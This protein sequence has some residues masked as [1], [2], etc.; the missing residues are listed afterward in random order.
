MTVV[1][2]AMEWIPAYRIGFYEQLRQRLDQLDVRLRVL[3][4]QPPASR[5]ARRDSATL[6]WFEE[7]TNRFVTV[8]RRELTLQTVPRDLVDVDVV[9]V[10]HEVGLLLNYPLAAHR[11]LSSS[12]RLGFWGHG[13]N[14]VPGLRSSRIESVRDSL[15][16]RGD[17]IFAYTERSK[18][19]YL[20]AG[21]PAGRITVV[22][23]S[24]SIPQRG[25][26]VSAEISALVAGL[27]ARSAHV[28]WMSSALDESKD[29]ERLIRIID[30]TRALDPDFEFVV[31]GG[32]PAL[33]SL[34]ATASR[35]PWMHVVGP[36]FGSDQAAIGEV[37][38]V[39]IHPGLLGLHVI[40]AMAFGAP[41]VTLDTPIHS[42]EISYLTD[43]RNAMIMPIESSDSAVAQI[44]VE[45]L[46]TDVGTE[47]ANQGRADARLLTVEAM[48]ERFVQGLLTMLE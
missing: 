28:G 43:R 10:Q 45:V 26:D 38:S 25:D 19:R 20:H 14:P 34:R 30:H 41:I 33:D 35:R 23:N 21:V 32:G 44:A 46:T 4:G 5:S 2:L 39:T 12:P 16:R 7:R 22:N 8:G 47:L 6:P 15:A 31:V 11:Q 3:H 13:E 9:V 36:R 17:R 48:V 37:A 18:E 40:D 27:E 24:K 42:H 29:L 1:A